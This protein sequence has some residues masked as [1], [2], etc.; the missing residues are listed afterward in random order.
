MSERVGNVQRDQVLQLLNSALEEGYLDLDEYA[1]RMTEATSARTVGDLAGQVADLPRQFHWD[2]RRPVAIPAGPR[3][4]L[5]RT[6]SNASL[7]LA[8]LSIPLS[9]C[10]GVG[11][12]FG[13]VAVV[14]S[15]PG[16]QST[17]DRGKAMAGAFIGSFGIVLSIV[18]VA[19]LV[20]LRIGP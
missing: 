12:L 20:F 14:L 7:A 13:I 9:V 19:L 2:P 5:T 15:R 18:M 10:Y 6:S 16:L 17:T 3:S 11:G 4:V 1:R 8:I